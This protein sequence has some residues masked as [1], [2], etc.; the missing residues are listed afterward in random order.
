M[1]K[2]DLALHILRQT[3][4]CLKEK[5]KKVIG[6]RK[7]ELGGQNGKKFVELRAKTYCY[8]TENNEENKKEKGIKKCVIKRNLKFRDY[9]KLF[10]SNSN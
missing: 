9:K 3:D 8:I 10:K 6:L 2:K 1:L 4:R 5:N 7:D